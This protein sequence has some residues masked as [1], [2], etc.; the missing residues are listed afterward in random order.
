MQHWHVLELVSYQ[1]TSVSALE[2]PSEEMT[3]LA[4]I[5]TVFLTFQTFPGRTNI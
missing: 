2:Q 4:H 1:M 3:P 5:D